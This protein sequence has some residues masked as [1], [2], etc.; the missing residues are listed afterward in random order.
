MISADG[1]RVKEL[2]F[3]RSDRLDLNV[4]ARE[5]GESKEVD[6]SDLYETA[7]AFIKYIGK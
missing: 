4:F 2:S 3:V 5:D 1:R 6:S 7:K